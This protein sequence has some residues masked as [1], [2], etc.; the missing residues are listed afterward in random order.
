MG[1]GGSGEGS[2]HSTDVG[3]GVEGSCDTCTGA[4]VGALVTVPAR[5]YGWWGRGVVVIGHT[6]VRG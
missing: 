1:S 4:W 3:A 6:W 2:S 5:V